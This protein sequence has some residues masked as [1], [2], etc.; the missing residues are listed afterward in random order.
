MVSS[1]AE[2][3][4]AHSSLQLNASLPSIVRVLSASTG[5]GGGGSSR[6]PYCPF[7]RQ[8]VLGQWAKGEESDNVG[9]EDRP[10]KVS[11][12]LDVVH[13]LRAVYTGDGVRAEPG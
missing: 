6:T 9:A 4:H 1:V 5:V 7:P 12:D 3:S 11:A 13:A 2:D 8:Q 10:A